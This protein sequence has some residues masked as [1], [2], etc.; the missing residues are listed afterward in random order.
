MTKRI[1]ALLAC[2][3][4][5]TAWLCACQAPSGRDGGLLPD[6]QEKDDWAS[7]YLEYIEYQVNNY[8]R[9]H[10]Y[11]LAYVNDDDIPELYVMGLD[12]AEGDRVCSYVNGEV[13][14]QHL[15][16]TCGGRYIE[17][18]GVFANRNGH[19]GYYYARVYQLSEGGFTQIFDASS[20]ERCV[21]FENGEYIFDNEYFIGELAVSEAEYDE[22][23][24]G[25]FDFS[26]AVYFCDS[27][28]DSETVKRQIENIK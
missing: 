17:R 22:A 18:S 3:T 24:S 26:N 7:A 20:T 13:V 10:F 6:A 11:S 15:S 9:E 21:G 1:I 25:A 14:E 19:M 28:V 2:L 23:V 4:A 5:L 16:R 8:D 12:E 27:A